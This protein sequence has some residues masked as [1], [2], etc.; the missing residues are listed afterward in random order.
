MRLGW[1][2]ARP[3]PHLKFWK[4]R[5]SNPNKNNHNFNFNNGYDVSNSK[6]EHSEGFFRLFL[7]PAKL[8]L[9]QTLVQTDCDA[10]WLD[11]NEWD[12][13]MKYFWILSPV[14]E[15]VVGE[16]NQ[17][18]FTAMCFN[19]L[20]EGTKMMV[21]CD[22]G[23]AFSH[24]QM[25]AHTH[26]HT[27]THQ[28]SSLCLLIWAKEIEFLTAFSSPPSTEPVWTTI[29]RRGTRIQIHFLLWNWV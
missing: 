21:Q 22:C 7:F 3:N 23:F 15:R 12:E 11:V 16:C 18:G 26:T 8:P 6:F 2:H 29:Q 24:A 17:T 4:C 14:G 13:R 28:S 1:P 19:V 20:K 10:W 5:K 25:A 27:H 9:S